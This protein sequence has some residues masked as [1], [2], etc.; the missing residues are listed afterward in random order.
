MIAL[1]NDHTALQM[2][3]WVIEVMNELG[4]E[5]EDFGVNTT[6][7]SDYPAQGELAARAVSDGRCELGIIICGTGI[8][9]GLAAN[10]V[11]G[12]RCAMVSEVYSAMMARRHNNANMMS[13]GARVLGEE[14]AKLIVRAFLSNTFDS[15]RH[16]R[17]VDMIMDI[18]SKG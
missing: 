16:G 5:Y 10:K 14:T 8:G 4:L 17:R 13:I 6:D 15:G 7:S 1:G 3:G 12:I 18:E 9:I 2:K 11:R